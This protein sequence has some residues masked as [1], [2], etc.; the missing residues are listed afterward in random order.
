MSLKDRIKASRLKNMLLWLMMHPVETRPRLWLRL[1]RPLYTQCAWSSV[2]HRNSR[3]DIVPFNR[4]TLG[5]RSV[6]ESFSCVNNAVGDVCIGDNSRVGLCNTIIGPVRIGDH[7]NLAQNIVVSGL[8]HGFSIPGKR[9]DEHKVETAPIIIGNDV[10]IGA[11]CTI[12]AGVRIGNHVIIGAG[13]VVTKS[14]PDNS[15]ALGVPA[16]VIKKI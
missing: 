15:L 3:M 2:I 8:N 1:L 16:K 13:S 14:I 11:N 4:F 5:K 12:T 7:V 10:W 6:I 9:I